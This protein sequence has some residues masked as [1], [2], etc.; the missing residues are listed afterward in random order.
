ML[1]LKV[2]I[3]GSLSLA[4][5]KAETI[6]GFFQQ[7]TE[8]QEASGCLSGKHTFHL[9]VLIAIHHGAIL[10]AVGHLVGIEV[11]ALGTIHSE[12][13]QFVPALRTCHIAKSVAIGKGCRACHHDVVAPYLLDEAHLLAHALG[14]DGIAQVGGASVHEIVGKTSIE[15]PFGV[16]GECQFHPT[17]R[18]GTVLL[19]PLEDGIQ[20]L[21]IPCR[22]VLHIGSILQAALYLQG[23]CTGIEQSLQLCRA[24][25]IAH[26]QEVA[27]RDKF[28]AIGRLKVVGHATELGTLST[29]GTTAIAHLGGI[30]TAIVANANGTMD[31]DLQGHLRHLAMYGGYLLDG[32]L[33]CKNHLFVALVVESLHLL[34][35]AVVHLCGGMQRD[36]RHGGQGSQPLVLNYEGIH[37][38]F[39][40]SPCQIASLAEFLLVGKQSVERDIHLHTEGMCIAHHLGNVLVA[41]SC[42]RT[43]TIA[44]STDINGVG[45]VVDGG[46]GALLVASRSKQFYLYLI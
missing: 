26:G 1:A 9:L 27:A 34:C 44:L 22:H 37:T 16:G 13:H 42:R 35:R 30:A 40:H 24:V 3:C 4:S 33:A 28:L 23:A 6:L 43:G 29:V 11:V 7:P 21:T 10:Q 46:K 5:G 12:A 32:E 15:T 39:V 8:G 38:Y 20:L 25:H 18:G 14:G 41:I 2:L 45:T 19:A 36:G 31:E 17:L